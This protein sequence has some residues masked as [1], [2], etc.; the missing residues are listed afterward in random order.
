MRHKL[1]L[2]LV[3]FGLAAAIFLLRESR[4]INTRPVGSLQT[5]KGAQLT[6]AQ[7]HPNK[8]FASS[9]AEL[10]PSHGAELID[11]VLAGG[12]VSGYVFVL[13]T[14]PPDFGGRIMHYA[15]VARP[16]QYRNGRLSFF[17]DESGIERF[18]VEDRAANINDPPRPLE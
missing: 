9:L 2:V 5:I 4:R 3:L 17:M 14:T 8:G 15:V 18:T 12:R 1:I 16:E 11:G 7:A 6:D 10:G 13:S